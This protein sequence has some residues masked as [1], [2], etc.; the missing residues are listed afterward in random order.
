MQQTHLKNPDFEV[1]EIENYNS[2]VIAE[3][4]MKFKKETSFRSVIGSLM[5]CIW[6]CPRRL[7]AFWNGKRDA[8]KNVECQECN[9][10][11]C[12]HYYRNGNRLCDEITKLRVKKRGCT[13]VLVLGFCF[14]LGKTV[15]S[16]SLQI[17]E[18][19]EHHHAR[20]CKGQL[21]EVAWAGSV[22][23]YGVAPH[24]EDQLKESQCLLTLAMRCWVA[25]ERKG[26]TLYGGDEVRCWV[27][28]TIVRLSSW[29][30]ALA[31]KLSG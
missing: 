2:N 25:K 24:S 22:S 15:Q 27:N 30:D 12:Q 31:G 7:Y 28:P 17:R 26:E 21:D 10:S 14:L 3:T 29:S 20:R 5:S 13:S 11:Y 1:N 16:I 9:V 19:I 6:F 18:T 4:P 23:R 8:A